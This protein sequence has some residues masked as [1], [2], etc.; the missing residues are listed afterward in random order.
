M[1][2]ISVKS[3]MNM[4]STTMSLVRYSNIIQPMFKEGKSI[5]SI[6][7][8][9]QKLNSDVTYYQVRKFLQECHSRNLPARRKTYHPRSLAPYLSTIKEI[10]ADTY[11]ADSSATIAF[12]LGRL[13]ERNI[14]VSASQVRDIRKMLGFVR[15]TTKY[16]HM[17]R[18]V[19]KEKRIDF[20]TR[21]IDSKED[22]ANCIFTDESTVQVDC[23]VK[24]CYVKKGDFYS[25]LRSKAKHPVK[26]HLWGGISMRGAT[27]LAIFPGEMRLNSQKYCEILERCF[28]RFNRSIYNGNF[29]MKCIQLRQQIKNVEQL[30]DAVLAFWKTLT[31]EVCARYVKGI[32]LRMVKVVDQNGRNIEE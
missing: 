29:I 10:I 26:L 19:N 14:F 1:V 25:R 21:M 3:I 27:E 12:I 24:Y 9:L 18:D 32:Q 11:K 16:C 23:C 17:I 5:S 31:P 28:V 8:E 6:H 2:V 15:A 30:R 20:C 7:R 4:S 13:R 22:F